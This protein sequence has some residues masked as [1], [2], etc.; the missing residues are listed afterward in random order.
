MK[1]D[2]RQAL[3]GTLFGVGGVGLRALATGLPASFF[4][5][6]RKAM[7]SGPDAG[8]CGAAR[9]AQYVIMSINERGC[10]IN[11]VTPGVYGV[12]GVIL[13]PANAGGANM[14]PTSITQNGVSVT[15][16]YPWSTLPQ[17]VLDRTLFFHNQTSIPIHSQLPVA[18]ELGDSSKDML[19]SLLAAATAA[20]LNTIQ[21][22]PVVLGAVTPTE[23]VTFGGAPL[24]VIPPSSLQDTLLNPSGPG[25]S[26]ISN[27]Q[28]IRDKTMNSI[29]N[30]YARSGT[31]TQK[32]YVNAFANTQTEARLL[33]QS[34]L[35]QLGAISYDPYDPVGSATAELQAAVILIQMNVAPV[36]S[37]RL[38]FGGD[39]H[40]DLG[41][42]T[43][44]TS[45]TSAVKLLGQTLWPLLQ[46]AGLQ[47]KVCFMTHNVFGRTLGAANEAAGG[48]RQHNPNHHVSVCMGA[49]FKGGVI[50]GCGPA[51]LSNTMDFGCLNID[52]ASGSALPASGGAG[53][54]TVDTLGAFGMTML[55]AV[56][57]DPT[58]APVGPL[59]TAK[60]VCGALR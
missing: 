26:A 57:G 59:G 34:L 21:R 38:S 1:I 16:A 12:P 33:S 14:T 32:A 23:D 11:A 52:P 5:N 3:L 49:P 47:D 44:A 56:G 29:Y 9:P 36:F 30:I 13:A 58:Q 55:A 35:S 41:Y 19:P 40:T 42:A 15:G 4:L 17:A 2:R 37:V 60:V 45:T 54:S 18:L 25:L 53:I 6:P 31:P 10:P 22:Q 51:A 46:A 27:L 7:A 20:S 24:P 50:G 28:Q 8:A 39:T 48:G 43:E